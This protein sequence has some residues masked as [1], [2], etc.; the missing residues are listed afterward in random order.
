MGSP[1]AWALPA[2]SL[3]LLLVIL[4]TDSNKSAFLSINS[5]SQITGDALW[6]NLTVLGDGLIVLALILCFDCQEYLMRKNK[7]PHAALYF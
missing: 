6:A 2:L 1:L 5:L 4:A 7:G 3:A